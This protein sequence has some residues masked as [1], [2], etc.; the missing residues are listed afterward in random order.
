RCI[1]RNATIEAQGMPSL[2][3][4]H[5]TV[6]ADVTTQIGTQFN[7]G[8]LMG[9][10][11]MSYWT[12]KQPSFDDP[13]EKLNHAASN[14]YKRC[15]IGDVVWI[16]TLDDGKLHLVGR[17]PVKYKVDYNEACQMLKRDDLWQAN[18]HIISDP[19][20]GDGIRKIL[21]HE[22]ADSLRFVSKSDA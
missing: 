9:R 2:G 6:A 7:S 13:E 15:E 18:W 1:S 12:S 19:Q 20:G 8:T 4:L 21:I 11:F 3:L 10:H 17:I 16:V 22:F 14:Q 5:S